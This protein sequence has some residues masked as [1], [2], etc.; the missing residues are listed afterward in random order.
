M[1]RVIS[2]LWM[3]F[4]VMVVALGSGCD[5][6][7]MEAVGHGHEPGGHGHGAENADEPPHGPH[8]GRLLSD[9]DMALEMTIDE[10]G[11]P[12]RWQVY[13]YHAGEPMAAD[14][15]SATVTL[16]RLDGE[17]NIF[18]LRP[19]A[20]ALVSDEIVT[21]PH[22][23]DVTVA[24]SYRQRT[25]QWHYET[26][27][28]RVEISSAMAREMGVEVEPVG[29]VGFEQTLEVLGRISFAPDAMATVRAQFPG[30][31][32]KVTKTQ[33]DSV[34]QGDVMAVIEATDSLREYSIRAPI[35]GVVIERQTN[36]GD[37][38]RDAPLFMLGDLNRLRVNFHIYPGDFNLIRPGQAVKIHSI[39]E[40]S[41]AE[42]VISAYLPT[43][44]SATQTIIAYAPLLNP[45]EYWLPG[46][47]V[48]GQVVVDQAEIPLAV[49]TQALQAFR[50]FTVVFAR[51]GDQYEVRMLELGRQNRQWAE[52]LG[53]IK[54]GQEYV[55][56]NS[57]LI[58]ADI[59]KSGA[60]HD[61]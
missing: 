31:V 16:G 40:Q 5:Q 6:A 52:V 18:Q 55:T 44:E 58:K 42:S 37:V 12:P 56:K 24:A 27:E 53:G 45:E 59:E 21:E 60:S 41:H 46:M 61:H 20:D 15:V 29:P 11:R 32:I 25:Y 48:T 57:F 22:S 47:M 17:M 4:V 39:N 38:A 9:G 28:G 13:P 33:G 50:D 8:G 34:K 14:Q 26:Y 54:P 36:V 43:T 19:E 10:S 49:R 3:I 1:N 7:R 35:D 23:F 2:I 30:R 51:V